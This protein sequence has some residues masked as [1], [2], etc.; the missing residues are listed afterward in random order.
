VFFALKSTAQ[1]TR[2]RSNG[3]VFF[4]LKSTAQKTRFRSNGVVFFAL[5]STAQKTRF[6]SNGVVFLF[7]P[8]RTEQ[9]LAFAQENSLVIFNKNN[10]KIRV[11]LHSYLRLTPIS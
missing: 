11:F 3:V 6:R 8:V 7:C 9:K 1:K 2:F 5:K 10:A 4:A